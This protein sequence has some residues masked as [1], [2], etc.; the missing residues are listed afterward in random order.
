MLNLSSVSYVFNYYSNRHKHIV[1]ST[2]TLSCERS[3]VISSRQIIGFP[4]ILL[5]LVC[6]DAR[7]D[8]L[9]TL[10]FRASENVQYDSNVFRLSDSVN[11]QALIGTPTRSDTTA[12]TSVGVKLNKPYGL[13]RFELDVSATDHRYKRFSGLNFTA[14]DYAAA[15][16]WSLT[17]AFHGNF[18]S[19]RREYVD[20]TADVQSVGALNRRTERSTLLDAEYELGAAWRLLGGVSERNS[21][22]SL[23]FTFEG[24]SKVRSAEAGVGYVFAS[25]TSLAYRLKNGNGEYSNLPTAIPFS[26]DFSQREHEFRFELPST[27]RT[28]VRGRMSHL[29]RDHD[30]LAARDFSGFT[31]QLDATYAITGK[32]SLI[33][34]VARDLGSYQTTTS[35]YYESM[36]LFVGPTWKATEKIALRLRY[37]RDARKYKGPLPGFVDSGRRDTADLVTLAVDWEPIR[38][39]KVTASAQR[40]QRRSNLSGFDYKSNVFGLAAQVNF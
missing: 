23:P 29:S 12:V 2:F 30:V 25:G 4:L 38:A 35:S 31:G 40:D 18:T 26:S 22:S 7:A 10:Q 1:N 32:T 19:D 13:Q 39:V 33:G 8:E 3:T 37:D 9:D 21:T 36:R 6:V 17:P 16:R 27:G 5:G 34:G 14:F 15:W 28:T 20:T 11:A 24:N